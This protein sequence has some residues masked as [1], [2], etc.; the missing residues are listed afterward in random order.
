MALL[1]GLLVFAYLLR[2]EQEACGGPKVR[3]LVAIKPIEVGQVLADDMLATR[4]VPLAYVE[5][6]AVRESERARVVGLRMSTP[7]RAQETLMWTDLAI[8]TD[9]RRDLSSLVQ[10]GMRAVT[11]RASTEGSF[12]LIRPGDRVDVIATMAQGDQRESIVLLQNVLVLAVGLDTG[13][14]GDP[15]TKRPYADPSDQI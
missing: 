12:A 2:F 9:D 7:V 15:G 5:D 1:G 3:L 11:V 8:A 6:R 4:D 10:P 13:A 14:G